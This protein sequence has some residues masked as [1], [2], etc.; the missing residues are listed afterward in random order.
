MK[1]LRSPRSG[2]TLIEFVLTIAV[3]GIAATPILSFFAESNVRSVAA[4]MHG[5]A[6]LLAIDGAEKVLADRHSPDRGLSYVL[7]GY[8]PDTPVLGYSRSYSFREVSEVDLE[9]STSGT[10]FYEFTVTVT[11]SGGDTDVKVILCNAS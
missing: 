8:S 2:Y 7:S 9:T 10:G 11:Y 1:H 5:I 4:E 3:L 6:H